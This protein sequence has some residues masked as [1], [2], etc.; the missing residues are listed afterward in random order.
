MW[1]SAMLSYTR[2][3]R[4]IRALYRLIS[5]Q[6]RNAVTN[7]ETWFR[8]SLSARGSQRDMSVDTSLGR[9]KPLAMICEGPI[10]VVYRLMSKQ[11]TVKVG[12]LSADY[13]HDVWDT[14]NRDYSNNRR[15]VESPPE[16]IRRFLARLSQPIILSAYIL[17]T[18][19]SRSRTCQKNRGP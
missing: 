5:K 15:I 16:A 11:V 19:R 18:S 14:D 4:P 7:M 3:E 1:T 10:P 6:R 2:C 12:R 8:R 9:G 17:L 13:I